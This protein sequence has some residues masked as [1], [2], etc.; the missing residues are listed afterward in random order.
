M[1][2]KNIINLLEAKSIKPT[3]HRI[4][5]LDYIIKSKQHPTAEMI[6]SDIKQDF[7][8]I[9]LATV[10]NTLEVL[11]Q[12]GLVRSIKFQH[13]ICRF[14]FASNDHLHIYVSD[15]NEIID[16]YDDDLIQLIKNKL[17]THNFENY[18]L[19]NI[20]IE[21]KQKGASNEQIS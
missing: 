7:P 15:T 18:Q 16:L 1:E 4:I 17:A 3:I 5:I 8:T 20:N 11:E 12:T 6:Y 19:E 10:Y 9:S 14:D 21:L 13:D 2:Q